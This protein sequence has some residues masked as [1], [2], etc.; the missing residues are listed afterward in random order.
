MTAHPRIAIVGEAMI[1]LSPAG[2]VD[3][4][5]IGVAGDTFNAGVYMSRLLR[6]RGAQ[7]A[8]VTLLGDDAQSDRI[9]NAMQAE[10]IDTALVGRV[11]GAMPGL[12]LIELDAKGERSFSYWRA[13]SAARQLF[14]PGTNVRPDDLAG[15]DVVFLSA[16]TLAILGQPARDALHDWAQGFRAAGG[17]IAFDSN[18]RP[19]L[20][21]DLATAQRE[22]AR[23]WGIT[24]IAL[25]SVDDEMAL[26]G[27]AD[28]DAVIA[29]LRGLGVSQGALKCGADGPVALDGSGIRLDAAPVTSVVDTTAAGDSFD[30]GFLA[31]FLSGASVL[32][33]MQAGHTLACRVIG[34]RGAIIP[35]DAM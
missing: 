34:H 30:A 24:D 13:H 5:R 15:F 22:V 25:P 2:P 28:A 12:Y 32:D 3:T 23:F 26:F 14:A 16:I 10:G 31:A 29:R 19:R 17:R 20:W 1:E 35:Q 9:A 27:D 4:L 21:P 18:Y 7:V 11:P 33:A 6:G 8:Y